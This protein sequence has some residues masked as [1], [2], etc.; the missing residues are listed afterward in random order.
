MPHPSFQCRLSSDRERGKFRLSRELQGRRPPLGGQFLQHFSSCI[1][2]HPN[3]LQSEARLRRWWCSDPDRRRSLPRQGWDRNSA[4]DCLPRQDAE[5]VGAFRPCRNHQFSARSA[6]PSAR[7][8]LRNNWPSLCGPL[9]FRIDLQTRRTPC[10]APRSPLTPS[11]TATH[12][13]S[14]HVPKLCRCSCFPVS[15]ADPVSLHAASIGMQAG[16]DGGI[17]RVPPDCSGI[18]RTGNGGRVTIAFDRLEKVCFAGK[19]VWSWSI[20]TTKV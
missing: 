5:G 13:H 12:P 6:V 19:K 18:T 17:P 3:L 20:A 16:P 8:N 14:R 15:V 7:R 10:H 11:R 2:R 4:R 9:Q 1:P